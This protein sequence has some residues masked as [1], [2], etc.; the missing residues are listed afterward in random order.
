MCWI[1]KTCL[2]FQKKRTSRQGSLEANRSVAV[3]VLRAGIVVPGNRIGQICHQGWAEEALILERAVKINNSTKDFTNTK[4]V[5]VLEAAVA[6]VVEDLVTE[7]AVGMLWFLLVRRQN[8]N[9]LIFFC[10][11][12]GGGGGGGFNQG[13]DNGG[14]GGGFGFNAVDNSQGFGSGGGNESGGFGTFGGEEHGGG[15]GFG[16]GFGGGADRPYR[17]RGRGGRG[18]GGRGF[19][20]RGRQFDRVS[21]SDRTGIKPVDKRDG[22]GSY[23]WGSQHDPAGENEAVNLNASAEGEQPPVEGGGGDEEKR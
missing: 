4:I 10:R 15:G 19:G 20:G 12:R 18:R 3:D 23:N 8:L 1:R 9:Y 2:F 5:A 16:G 11:G 22:S 14:G 21:G 6:V 13:D 17:G 7:E